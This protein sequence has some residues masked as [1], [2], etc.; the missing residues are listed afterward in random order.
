[1]P[2]VAVLPFA[3]VG[4]NPANLY[5]SDGLTGEITDALTHLKG[6]RVIARS[7]ANEFRGKQKDLR[8]IGRQLNVTHVLEGSVERSGDR[9]KIVARLDRVSDVSEIWSNTYERQSSDLFSLQSELASGIAANLGIPAGAN[10]PAKHV[11]QDA[12]AR[13]ACMRGVYEMEHYSPE[14]FDRASADFKHA[15]DRDPLYAQA[16]VRLGGVA[17]NRANVT[18]SGTLPGTERA[19]IE[20]LL[21]K[22]LELDPEQGEARA[23]LASFTMQNDW[24]W[25]RAEQEYR[26]ALGH[27]PNTLAEQAYAFLLIFEGRFGEAE[28]YLQT[29]RTLNPFSIGQISNLA[30]ARDVE[31]RFEEARS[32]Y[33]RA[34]A[35][36]P[37]ALMPRVLRDFVDIEIGRTQEALADFKKLEPLYPPSP[38]FEAMAQARAGRRDEA[39]KLVTLMEDG[40]VNQT[41]P[42]DWFALVYAFLG[43]EGKTITYLE[44]SADR[45]EYQAMYMGVHPYFAFLR[46]NPRFRALKKRMGLER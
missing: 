36:H 27:G 4:G 26:A 23:L 20:K 38:I 35:L 31:G 24:D 29:A 42:C 17:L 5:L 15:I 11:V 28:P 13:D 41:L 14:S 19:N 40:R 30:L 18:F 43:D 7:S 39:L 10:R 9:V 8:T 34:L 46:N 32:E 37:D 21:R 45:R 22:A 6:L 25:G 12:E 2:S 16:Y 33:Q 1:M 44:M 3:N